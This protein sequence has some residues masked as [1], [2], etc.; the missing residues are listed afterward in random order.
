MMKSNKENGVRMENKIIQKNI[1]PNIDSFN[2]REVTCFHKPWAILFQS[3]QEEY[4]DLYLWTAAFYENFSYN[5][6]FK[7]F[8]FWGNLNE[9][10]LRFAKEI[11]QPR[12]GVEIN[13]VSFQE[14][15]EFVERITGK[16]EQ[17]ERVLIP[18]D[19]IELPYYE[20]YKIDH[21][22]HF[23]VIR[24]FDIEKR[25]FYV[26]DNMQIDGGAGGEYKNFVITFEQMYLI[27][28]KAFE[29]FWKDAKPFFWT[30]K[31][32]SNERKYSYREA[33]KNHMDELSLCKMQGEGVTY[34]EEELL[35]ADRKESVN[36]SRH[37]VKILNYKEVYYELLWVIMR[38]SGM[39]A[40]SVIKIQEKKA[41]A[42]TMWERLRTKV[43][44]SYAKNKKLS[45][46]ED[47]FIKCKEKDYEM[48]EML[49]E[50]GERTISENATS[51]EDCN[52][53]Q[54]NENYHM[55]IHNPGEAIIKNESN[56][57]RILHEK[58]KVYDTWKHQ[59]NAPQV[60][61]GIDSKD[62]VEISFRLFLDNKVDFPFF[63]GVILYDKNGK[64]FLF[65][66]DALCYIALYCPQLEEDFILFKHE[67]H[68]KT[69]DLKIMINNGEIMF[70]YKGIPGAEWNINKLHEDSDIFRVGI[71]S[72]T[73]NAIK[74][75]SIFYDF[76]IM[77]NNEQF[78]WN[79]L[80]A[81]VR[82]ND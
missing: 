30:L 21:H 74:H 20:D 69:V 63:G 31:D 12:F 8:D 70:G 53:E 23:F 15:E 42:T 43:L 81:G 5:S 11:L 24:G 80:E 46:L 18:A 65:G 3:I 66:D 13:K 1:V 27:A 40:Q 57:I 76:N 2:P 4:F 71:I 58:E 45:D 61:F 59:N 49:I 56:K 72:K 26:L 41:E 78:D 9:N 38:K 54:E 39:V 62:N 55:F 6:F 77:I 32:V 47:E 48:F 51:R 67:F 82:K 33:L 14:D 17:G 44:L 36:Y 10:F 25:I 68:E 34:P 28:S 16:I 75:E 52:I 29:F 60:L 35:Y 7:W 79:A 37:Y 73:W 22:I 19:L 64:T 50:E